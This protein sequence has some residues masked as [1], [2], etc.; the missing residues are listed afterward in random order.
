VPDPSDLDADSALGRAFDRRLAIRLWMVSRPHRRLILGS[1]A[2]FPLVSAVELLQPYLMKL[3]I[4]GHILRGDWQGLTPV[5]SAFVAVLGALYGLRMAE[6][7]LM[8]LIGQRVMHDLRALLFA[9]LTRLDARFFDKNP[10][11]RLMTRVLNDVDAVS[12]AFTSGLFAVVAD[13]V[14]LAGV[15]ASCCGWTGASPS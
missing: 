7:Y 2:L 15:V 13:V 6:S 12:E 8:H 5:A 10:V 14:T 11:G 3:A 1:L 4:D 9:H